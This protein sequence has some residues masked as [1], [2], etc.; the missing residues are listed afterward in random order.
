MIWLSG[1]DLAGFLRNAVRSRQ[2]EKSTPSKCIELHAC[3]LIASGSIGALSSS[4]TYND[5]ILLKN[6]MICFR[7]ANVEAIEIQHAGLLDAS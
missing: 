2:T 3:E 1:A 6:I 4:C 5:R 7:V